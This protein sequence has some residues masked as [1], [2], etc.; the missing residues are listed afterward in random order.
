MWSC[1]APLCSGCGLAFAQTYLILLFLVGDEKRESSDSSQ[2]VLSPV[3]QSESSSVAPPITMTT[4]DGYS[5]VNL[6]DATVTE[7]KSSLLSSVV[8]VTLSLNHSR[9]ATR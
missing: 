3:N 6:G 9:T 2:D 4:H 8:I 1:I 5:S 7:V